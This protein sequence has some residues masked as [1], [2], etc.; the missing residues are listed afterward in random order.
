MMQVTN[1]D[2]AEGRR[3]S[4]VAD[5]EIE[6][7]DATTRA[8]VELYASYPYPAHG[9]VSGLVAGM[10]EEP[11]A[12]ARARKPNRTVKVLDAGCGT[13]EQTVGVS[14][15]NQGLHVVGIDISMTSL[16]FA[17]R[18]AGRAGAAVRFEQRDLMKPIRGLGKFDVIVSVGALHCLSDPK[19][20]FEHIRELA[21]DG[22][23]FLGMVYGAF[24]RAE[25]FRVRD[26]LTCLCGSD[27]SRADRLSVL[28]SSRLAKHSGPLHYLDVLRQ[29][30]RF[31]P[32]LPVNEAV[33]RVL[34]GRNEAYLADLFTHV[35]EAAYTWAEIAELLD[36]SGWKLEGWPRRSGMP[37][38]PEQL[39]RGAA[40]ERMRGL[41][42]LEQAAVYERLIC[43]ANLYFLASPK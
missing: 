3:H 7:V 17:R 35:Q 21:A 5:A 40:L 18:L 39:F 30:L 11:I 26:A 24:G 37:D 32:D 4:G 43:P 28:R 23:T 15:R 12:A 36:Q 25:T 14:S 16:Q 1:V 42:L 34:S 8:V 27:T 20:G 19:R 6:A 9:V 41:P 22:A 29:R 33:R 38:A 13:G 2:E 10:L 31:G